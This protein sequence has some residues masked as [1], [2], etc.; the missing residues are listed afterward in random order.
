VLTAASIGMLVALRHSLLSSIDTAARDDALDIQASVL[1]DG[2]SAE[3]MQPPTPDAAVQVLNANEDVV[4]RTENAPL[5]PL[6]AGR[7]DDPATITGTGP[8]SVPQSADAYR[9]AALRTTNGLT[10]LVALPADDVKDATDQLA[11][12]LLLGAP[13]LFVLLVAVAWLVT[14]RALAPLSALHHRQQEFVSDAAHE[15]RSPLASLQARLE[16]LESSPDTD[17]PAEAPR[18]RT[19]VARLGAI[20]DGLLALVRSADGRPA[21]VDVDL[22]DVARQSVDRL[23]ERT[24]HRLDV[25]VAPARVRGD[26]SALARLVDNLLDNAARHATSTVTV[27]L[28]VERGTALLEVA[29]DG[30]GIRPGDRDRVFG[31]FTRLDDARSRDGGG[32]GLG[33]A[34]VRA[35]AEAHGGDVSVTDAAPGAR[36]DVRRP[37]G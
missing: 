37:A 17:L 24:T 33:L 6:I 27:T 21:A 19:E 25:S 2:P 30:P 26:A 5:T 16:L 11:N 15:L 13:I 3:G 10:I 12:V 4:A 20:V 14:G 8:L 34:N 23:R 28:H 32:A 36:L 9:V 35:V 1:Q 18:L 22:D 31:R 7:G 29:D